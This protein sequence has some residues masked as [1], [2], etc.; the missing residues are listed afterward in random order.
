[1]NN[2]LVYSKPNCVFCDRLKDVLK[3]KNISYDEIII[4]E[5]IEVRTFLEKYPNIK[6]V[7][8]VFHENEFIG[9]YDETTKL[10]NEGNNVY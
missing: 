7:P 3:N 8:A 1:M 2:L 4:G 9:G 5:D 10:I 6:T